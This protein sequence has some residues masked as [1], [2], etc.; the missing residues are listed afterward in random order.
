MTTT[1]DEAGRLVIPKSIRERAGLRPGIPIEVEFVRG[2][3]EI[4][5]AVTPT[6]LVDEDGVA[7]LVPQGG[8]VVTAEAVRQVQELVRDGG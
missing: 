6:R 2:R 3:V 1:I 4:L 5:P 8:A 7:V